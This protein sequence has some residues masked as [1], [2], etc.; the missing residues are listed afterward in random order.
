MLQ[1]VHAAQQGGFARS[2]RAD[3]AH[4]L[5]LMNLEVDAFQDF[6]GSV[7][8][9]DLLCL[10]HHL[11]WLAMLRV[12]RHLAPFTFFADL[13]SRLSIWDWARVSTEVMMPYQMTATISI[14]ICSKVRA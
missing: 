2:R 14:G 12:H 9:A 1:M 11:A 10:D 5:A 7:V 8:L 6:E 3:D 4:D 13:F